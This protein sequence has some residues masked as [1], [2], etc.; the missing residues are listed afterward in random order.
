MSSLAQLQSLINKKYGLEPA[1]LDPHA[2]MR[3]AGVDSLTLVE[4]IFEVEDHFKISVPEANS[5]IDTLADLAAVV[6]NLLADQ[7]AVQTT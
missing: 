5:E 6:D 1:K 2:S 7:P 4:F 3:G